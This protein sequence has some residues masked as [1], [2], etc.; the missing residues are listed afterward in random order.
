MSEISPALVTQIGHVLP[1]D[2]KPVADGL[3]GMYGLSDP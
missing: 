2:G 1:R 3:T